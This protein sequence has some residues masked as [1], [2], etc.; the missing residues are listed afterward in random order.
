MKEAYENCKDFKLLAV[1]LKELKSPQVGQSS[2]TISQSQVDLS[3]AAEKYSYEDCKDFV[4][5]AMDLKELE[6]PQAG[7]SSNGIP[8]QVEFSAAQQGK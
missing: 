6:S 2:N 1:D 4:P 3:I 7:Q 8:Q 5:S